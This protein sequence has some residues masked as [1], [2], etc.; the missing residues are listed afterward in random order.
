MTLVNVANLWP[1]KAQLELVE[2][3]RQLEP[4][5]PRVVLIG[6]TTIDPDYTD[7]VQRAARD[8]EL[9]LA[10]TLPAA[11]VAATGSTLGGSVY[12]SP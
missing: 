9:T 10:G 8:V 7:Q 4:P 3:V 12:V 5:R 6:N 11:R 1:G 2:M